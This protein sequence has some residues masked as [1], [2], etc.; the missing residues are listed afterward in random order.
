MQQD[1]RTAHNE[2][3]DAQLGRSIAV[4]AA[5]GIPVVFLVSFMISLFAVGVQVAAAIAAWPALVGGPFF[6]GFAMMMWTLSKGE[7]L[8]SVASLEQSDQEP[9]PRFSQA[10]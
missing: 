3:G 2:I 5:I 4:G 9:S 1:S 6:G 10:A 7:E 8:A